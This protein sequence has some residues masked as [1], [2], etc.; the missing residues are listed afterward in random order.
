MDKLGIECMNFVCKEVFVALAT[1]SIERST[2]FYRTLLAIA[3]TQEIP[4]V[5]AEF[6]LPGLKL[7]LFAPQATHRDE[8]MPTG[9][10]MSLCLEVAQL[11]AAIA[12]V[13]AAHAALPDADMARH[14]TGAITTVFHGREVYA[15]DPDGNRLILHEART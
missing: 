12:Q 9:G 6:L 11:E 13:Q 15:Y 4:G 1:F 7:G 8:F 2:Q 5:Y 10:T 3:P 14:P